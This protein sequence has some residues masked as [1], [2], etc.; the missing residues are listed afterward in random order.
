MPYATKEQKKIHNLANKTKN[1]W[2]IYAK[3]IVELNQKSV[4]QDTYDNI[5]DLLPKA[6]L[7]TLKIK[8]SLQ[9]SL[10]E[11][12]A[13]IPATVPEPLPKTT[14]EAITSK[15]YP[16]S[17][18]YEIIN[19]LDSTYYKE[20]CS[21]Y[22]INRIRFDQNCFHIHQ[23]SKYHYQKLLIHEQTISCSVKYD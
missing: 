12:V 9:E 1:K 7:D 14:K 5:K 20:S 4:T 21:H 2:I 15:K 23:H 13:N 16:I 8:G 11:L 3:R 22:N 17:L 6:F 18:V 10:T 19:N